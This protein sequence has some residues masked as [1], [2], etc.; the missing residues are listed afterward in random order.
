ME[1]A[2]TPT[3][4]GTP[5][6]RTFL[7]A[8]SS[9]VIGGFITLTPLV[10]GLAFFLD[11]VLR[12]RTK[13]KGGDSEGFLFV[14]NL[15]DLP[16]DGTPLR[17]QMRADKQDAWNVVAN[18]TIGTIYLRKMPGNQII[19]FNDT[20]P[21]LGCKVDYQENSKSFLCPCHASAFK[22]DGERTNKIPPRGL[23]T[24]DSKTDTSGRV[25]VKYQEFQCG[26]TQKGA[27]S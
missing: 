14:A 13:F 20:C 4:P 8:I 12:T 2:S 5:P 16:D 24:L 6:R 23:D 17:F 7:A 10:S 3:D 22:L 1:T 9:V 18:Q 19:A 26:V 11:P 25:W 15:S 21:H 27:V